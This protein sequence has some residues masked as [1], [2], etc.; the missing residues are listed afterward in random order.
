MLFYTV[1]QSR[2]FLM[3]LYAGLAVGLY[4]S[5]D[6]A[7]RKLFQAGKPLNLLMDL[8]FGLVMAGIVLTALV[9]AANGELRLYALMGVL[10]GYL[11][12]MGTIAPLIRRTC[13]AS[14]KALHRAGQKISGWKITKIL[15]K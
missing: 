10:C 9:C 2:I 3:M 6:S 5:A 4:A 12:F 1:G 11:I 8:V 15:F 14:S 13:A 7:L